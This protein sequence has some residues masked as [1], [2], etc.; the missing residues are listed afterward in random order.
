M[1]YIVYDRNYMIKKLFQDLFRTTIQWDT[2]D[3]ITRTTSV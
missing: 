2:E 3:E 1:I